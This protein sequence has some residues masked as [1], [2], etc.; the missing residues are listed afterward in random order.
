MT[1]AGGRGRRPAPSSS[2]TSRFSTTASGAIRPSDIS[3]LG[4]LSASAHNNGRQLNPGV[5]QTGARPLLPPPPVSPEV[6][7]VVQVHVGQ[8]RRYAAPLGRAFFTPRPR[9]V[10]QHA[11]IEPFLDQ[12]HDALV[13]N[14][15]LDELH[16]P[17]VVDG[18]EEPTDVGIEHPVHLP[19][20][21]S[22]IERIQRM[23]RAASR[24]EPVR[25]AEEVSLVDRV[26]HLNRR[27]LD[28]LVFQRGDAQRPLPP[29]GLGDV[30]PLDRPRSVRSA[31]QPSRQVR[32]VCLEGL[33][34]VL[35]RLAVDPRGGI[36]LQRVVRRPQMLDV[37][38][39]VQERRE[40]HLLVPLS[41][42]TYPLQRTQRAVPAQCPGRVLLARVPLGQAPSLHLLRGRSLGVVRR[43]RGYYGPVRLPLPVHRRRVSMD[44]PTRPAGPSPTGRQGLS[45]FSREVCPGM[46]GVSDRAGLHRV[47]PLRRVGYGL[48][49]S[50]TA[51]ASRR[52]FL[53]RLYTRP[54]RT[55]V[56]A[57]RTAAHDSG[58]VWAANPSPYDS[59]IRNTSPV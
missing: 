10:L 30:R 29:V 47:L 31:L 13:R 17:P 23:M 24:P 59:C 26:H 52:S 50:S 44:F 20:Q 51:S 49:P 4:P 28:E 25:E 32:E 41:C 3:V 36:P 19:R 43:L 15:M 55:P 57:S 11:G 34:V 22:R 39:V 58:P 35:P 6:E 27:A 2:S 56:N 16:Q 37:V 8:E 38:D 46:H 5:H 48:P 54:A 18:I 42:F 1:R 12:P 21:Q 40:P 45:R 33:P 53:S 14:P 9:P 7:R